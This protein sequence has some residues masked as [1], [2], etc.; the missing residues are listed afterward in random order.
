MDPLAARDRQLLNEATD[1]P[2]VAYDWKD[3]P[4]RVDE[5]VIEMPDGN[6]VLDDAD[7]I[8][9]YVIDVLEGMPKVME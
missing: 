1:D 5:S 4:I 8:R 6:L 7:E 3:Q 9:E 2:I